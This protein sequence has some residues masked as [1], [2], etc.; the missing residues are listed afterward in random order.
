VQSQTRSQAV[1]DMDTKRPKIE[2]KEHRPRGSGACTTCRQAKVCVPRI[3][4]KINTHYHAAATT[5]NRKLI[6]VIL[7]PL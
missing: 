2:I 5:S 6:S 7:D 1:E 4:D 3:E